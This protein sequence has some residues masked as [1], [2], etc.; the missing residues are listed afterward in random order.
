MPEHN[1][2]DEKQWDHFIQLLIRK[3]IISKR[4]SASQLFQKQVLNQYKSQTQIKKDIMDEV[5][6]MGIAQT[7]PNEWYTSV[8]AQEVTKSIFYDIMI[9]TAMKF[10]MVIST[11]EDF[12]ELVSIIAKERKIPAEEVI[13]D[14]QNIA[15]TIGAVRLFNSK[16]FEIAEK[17]PKTEFG[18]PDYPSKF[19]A[20]I[21]GIEESIAE[22]LKSGVLIEYSVYLKESENEDT[23]PS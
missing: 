2:I 16:Y 17:F 15:L 18:D 20:K 23:L 6:Y 19:L 4:C 22:S 7:I 11:S 5:E 14:T 10:N 21:L 12:D 9:S 8:E 3:Q 1:T 13:Q